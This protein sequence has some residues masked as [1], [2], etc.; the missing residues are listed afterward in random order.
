MAWTEEGSSFV[1]LTEEAD[2]D[3]HFLPRSLPCL[4]LDSFPESSL[5]TL[6]HQRIQRGLPT[7]A[8]FKVAALASPPQCWDYRLCATTSSFAEHRPDCLC[9]FPY[10]L[11]HPQ[12]SCVLNFHSESWTSPHLGWDILPPS[13]CLDI[14]FPDSPSLSCG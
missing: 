9:V 12:S 3:P 14:H 1:A 10:S 4:R 11:A 7:V 6:S 2:E 5:V 8:G 13:S